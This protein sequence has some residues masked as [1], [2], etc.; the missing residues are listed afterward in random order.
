MAFVLAGITVVITLGF[1]LLQAF[2]AGMSDAPGSNSGAGV[3][4]CI[5]LPL[6]GL[7]A[8]SHWWHFSW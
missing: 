4:L 8:W 5:G 6:A 3:T 2:A 7:I 1:A